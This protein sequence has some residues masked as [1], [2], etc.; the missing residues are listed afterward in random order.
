MQDEFLTG[1][2]TVFFGC[3]TVSLVHKVHGRY[4]YMDLEEG[5]YIEV[6]DAGERKVVTLQDVLQT[7]V[8][9]PSDRHTEWNRGE[10]VYEGCKARVKLDKKATKLVEENNKKRAIEQIFK[11][12]KHERLTLEEAKKTILRWETDIEEGE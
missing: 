1:R 6:G 5:D 2:L 4:S 12:V 8:E 7:I 3:D 10:S 9:K 11:A